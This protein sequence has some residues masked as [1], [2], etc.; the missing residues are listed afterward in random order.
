MTTLT[1]DEQ[2]FVRLSARLEEVCSL[3][4]AMTTQRDEALAESARLSILI[5]SAMCMLCEGPD[6]IG[7][8]E[9]RE[10]AIQILRGAR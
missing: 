4:A 10:Q 9:A 8:R 5:D 2:L 3:L 6:A 1:P 7:G